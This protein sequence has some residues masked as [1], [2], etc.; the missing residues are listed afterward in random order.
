MSQTTWKN[1]AREMEK[2]VK[3]VEGVDDRT[4]GP[5]DDKKTQ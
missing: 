3:E 4:Y 2:I 5:G 1:G